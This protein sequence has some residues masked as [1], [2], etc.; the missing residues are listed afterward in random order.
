MGLYTSMSHWP[1]SQLFL[2]VL[3][4]L[5]CVVYNFISGEFRPVSVCLPWRGLMGSWILRDSISIQPLWPEFC[6][7]FCAVRFG[8]SV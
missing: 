1:V 4:E 3:P 7:G 2:R 8:V 6:A 5:P